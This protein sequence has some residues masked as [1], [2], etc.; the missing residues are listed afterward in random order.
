VKPVVL[1]HRVDFLHLNRIDPL[2]SEA[3]K[4]GAVAGIAL[5]SVDLA[6]MKA[7]I[8]QLAVI[9]PAQD[10]PRAGTRAGGNCPSGYVDRGAGGAPGSAGNGRNAGGGRAVLGD[11]EAAAH[12][13]SPQS[14]CR[15]LAAIAA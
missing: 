1:Q 6:A 8:L 15:D 9:E 7:D 4:P 13:V 5:D 12:W 14:Q 3:E 11:G 10:A 2:G